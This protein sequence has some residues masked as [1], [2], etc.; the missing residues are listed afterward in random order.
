M[1]FVVDPPV[2]SLHCTLVYP[3]FSGMRRAI[4]SRPSRGERAAARNVRIAAAAE[5]ALEDEAKA[6]DSSHERYAAAVCAWTE[7]IH[8]AVTE[9]GR[10]P[11]PSA[12][13][14]PRNHEYTRAFWA[15]TVQP[16][17]RDTKLYQWQRHF[18]VI[19]P[20]DFA[21]HMQAVM[22]DELLLALGVAGDLFDILLTCCVEPNQAI[23]VPS[24]PRRLY[25]SCN[26][27]PLA[28]LFFGLGGETPD[29]RCEVDLITHRQTAATC[30]WV[31]RINEDARNQHRDFAVVVGVWGI[32]AL[33]GFLGYLAYLAIASAA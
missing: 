31:A 29:A 15:S 25:I 19:K 24:R 8:A 6:A 22:R 10:L 5:R 21:R 33:V 16:A 27:C 28:V 14:T 32:L 18:V 3:L 23:G 13:R 26:G 9:L 7:R 12:A 4:T 20:D 2:V 30:V 17:A 1:F 11:P